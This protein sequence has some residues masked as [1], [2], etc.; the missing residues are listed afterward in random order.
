MIV[1]IELHENEQKQKIHEMFE[2]WMM[3]QLKNLI[4]GKN[5]LMQQQK[6]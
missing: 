4:H 3:D 2:I 5:D 6:S 1:L